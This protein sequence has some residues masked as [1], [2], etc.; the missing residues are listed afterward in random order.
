MGRGHLD[1]LDLELE[2]LT[3][4]FV[5]EDGSWDLHKNKCSEPSISTAPIVLKYSYCF[6]LYG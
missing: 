3:K 4:H 5:G 1:F 6:F 2:M